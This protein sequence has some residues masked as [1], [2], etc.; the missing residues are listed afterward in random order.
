MILKVRSLG[1]LWQRLPQRGRE[2]LL[3][4]SIQGLTFVASFD[5]ATQLYRRWIAK[6][7]DVG[8]GLTSSNEQ[9]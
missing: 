8:D 2:F 9:I 4:G 1:P 6:R 3:V 7:L 5:V